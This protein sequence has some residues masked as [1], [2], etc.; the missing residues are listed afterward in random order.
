MNEAIKLAEELMIGRKIAQ[1]F[2]MEG[3]PETPANKLPPGHYH[4]NTLAIPGSGFMLRREFPYAPNNISKILKCRHVE[5][6]ETVF[7][8]E[9]INKDPGRDYKYVIFRPGNWVTILIHF[10]EDL[11]YKHDNREA[12][13]L[14]NRFS[15]FDPETGIY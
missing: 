12:I 11:K 3:L 6:G 7:H 13:R 15:G 4:Y 8:V 9:E 1:C 5:T 10:W 14:N 2:T